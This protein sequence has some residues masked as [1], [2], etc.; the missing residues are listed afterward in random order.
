MGKEGQEIPEMSKEWIAEISGRYIELYE[1]LTGLQFQREE[2]SDEET[3]A[4]VNR[5]LEKIT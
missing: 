4:R 5:A 2:I 3:T 1:R